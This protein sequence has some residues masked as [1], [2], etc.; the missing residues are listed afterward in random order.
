MITS[1]LR[2]EIQPHLITHQRVDLPKSV[3]RLAESI[4]TWS[5]T[6]GRY[7]LNRLHGRSQWWRRMVA[8]RMS[9]Y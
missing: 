2:E 4:L 8:A 7:R 1:W 9:P 5:S 3:L 6:Q